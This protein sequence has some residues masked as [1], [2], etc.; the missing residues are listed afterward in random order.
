MAADFPVRTCS[1]TLPRNAY[2][3]PGFASTDLSI[4]KDFGLPMPGARVQFRVEVFNLFNRV[5][6]QRPNGNMAQATFGRSTQS[7]AARE[8]QLA[9][10]LIF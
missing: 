8:I 5:N 1:A 2:R 4:F 7:F 3:G 6:L 10:K 9:L